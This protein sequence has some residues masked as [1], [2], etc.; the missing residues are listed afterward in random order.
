MQDI[1]GSILNLLRERGQA[2]AADVASAT[3]M[4]PVNAHY[5]L[6]KMER[7]GLVVTEPLR[8]GVGRPKFLYSLSSAALERFPQLAQRLTGRLLDALQS[9]LTT[10]Q[11][12]AVFNRMVDGI[13]AEHGHQFRDRSLEEKVEA[14]VG[15]LGEEGFI[16]R[17][18]KTGEEYQLTQ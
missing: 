1:R 13:A 7:E 6:S 5:H 8:Q 18:H 12:E 11:V 14:L 2:T 17:V 16:S 4:S 15:I 10:E 3:G 9:Q